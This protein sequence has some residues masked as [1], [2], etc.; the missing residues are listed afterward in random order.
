MLKMKLPL[1]VFLCLK[2]MADRNNVKYTSWAAKSNIH[3][4][5]ISEYIKMHQVE[6]GIE[7]HTENAKKRAFTLET[8]VALYKGLKKIIGE[9]RM[10]KDMMNC[11]ETE[12]DP[13]KKIILM[14]MV[15]AEEGDKKFIKMAA[16]YLELL[17]KADRK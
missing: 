5:R 1:S 10:K 17:F 3:N 9:D 2:D 14:A 16:E 7:K 8:A 11:I 12:S 6:I 4:T 13:L 15:K